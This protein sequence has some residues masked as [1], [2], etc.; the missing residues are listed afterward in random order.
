MKYAN[1][2]ATTA[3]VIV[4]TAAIPI[5]R[6]AM[7][8]YAEPFQ[9]VRKLSSV[10]CRTR[11][12]VNGSTDQNAETNSAASAATYTHRNASTG[13]ESSESAFNHGWRQSAPPTRRRAPVRE[14]A[15]P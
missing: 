10:Q 14:G 9:S 7:C 2:K 6:S 12:D 13:G 1:G 5:V 15:S 3:S 11:S 4:T 8:R